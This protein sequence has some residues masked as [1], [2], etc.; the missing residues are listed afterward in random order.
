[1]FNFLVNLGGGIDENAIPL[2]GFAEVTGLGQEFIIAEYRNG[3]EKTNHVQKVPGLHKVSDVTLKRGVVNSKDLWTWINQVRTQGIAGRRTVVITLLD[4]AGKPAQKWT[5]GKALPLK[6][7][8]PNLNGKGGTDVAMEELVLSAE[9][10]DS[11][12]LA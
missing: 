1:V 4:E 3:N 11:K 7:T 9:S 8:G 10:I 12:Q 2:G 5:L 6:Y